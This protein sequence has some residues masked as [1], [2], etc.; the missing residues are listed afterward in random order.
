MKT[1]VINLLR[2]VKKRDKIE[3]QLLRHP[4]LDYQ[5][6]EAIE[7]NKL[8]IEQQHQFGY[9]DFKNKYDYLGTLP[10]FGCSLSHYRVYEEIV[11]QNVPCALILEDDAIISKSL[12]K[13][14]DNINTF[15]S[16]HDEP[17]AILLTPDFIYHKN[18]VVLSKDHVLN[19]VKIQ[20]GYMTSGY[21]INQL[22]AELLS[23][24]L[25]PI[26]YIADE[27]AEF[28]KIGLKVY[29]VVPHLI[30]FPD[31]IGEIGASQLK[32]RNNWILWLRHMIGNFRA[33]FINKKLFRNGLRKS[34]KLW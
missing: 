22:G 7:G 33:Q 23:R 10:A 18:D 26:K 9:F 31:E 13:Q 1:Y 24:K 8:S 4:E 30:S 32:S 14:I 34:E 6:W 11:K 2:D 20:Y 27:W 19:V 16:S 17:L 12:V 21:I 25:F 29:G 5:I 3:Q 28:K 15:L